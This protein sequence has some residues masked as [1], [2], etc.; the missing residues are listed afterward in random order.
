MSTETERSQDRWNRIVV[1]TASALEQFFW[2]L[3]WFALLVVILFG[4]PCLRNSTPQRQD[5][6]QRSASPAR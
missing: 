3:A 6:E 5:Q 1:P 4:G 2:K